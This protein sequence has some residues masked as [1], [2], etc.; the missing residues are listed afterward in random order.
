MN[1]YTLFLLALL[2][3]LFDCTAA[4]GQGCATV[5]SPHFSAYNSVSRNG[6][7]I[8]TSVTMEG[9][10]SIA[11]GPGCNMSAATHKVDAYNKIGST[12]GDD[13]S[14]S[15]CPNCSYSVTNNQQIV[16]T[17]GGMNMILFGTA[18]PFVASWAPSTA[19]AMEVVGTF[20]A[21]SLLQ[22]RQ[23]KQRAQQV[24]QL[25]SS[26]RQSAIVLMTASTGLRLLKA[27]LPPRRTHV[28][29]KEV[30]LQNGPE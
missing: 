19:T 20:R 23:P 17:P 25:R 30:I 24:Q 18:L 1:R 22:P 28:F 5:L 21:V 10:A 7:N 14:P 15:G 4:H 8:Y 2:M 11:Q 12:G 26:I 9:Y 3:V 29:L 27:M 6:K 16:G 13:Y